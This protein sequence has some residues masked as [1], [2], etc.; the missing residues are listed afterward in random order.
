MFA[1]ACEMG[2]RMHT[3]FPAYAPRS[4]FYPANF[5]SLG[6]GFPAAIGGAVGAPGRW[7]AC[8]AGDGGFMMAAQELATAVRYRLKLI[9]VVHNDSAYGAIKVIQRTR[10]G[11]RYLDTDLNNL[12]FVALGDSFGVPSCRA[13]NAVELAAAL[14]QA[15]RRD[16][17]SLIEVP[18]EW[19]SLRM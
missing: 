12:N 16:G 6:W 9:T 7:A 17:P 14:R 3:D 11:A 2:L 19:R 8:V 18:E 13:G 10:H 1:D 4:F 5:A 15:L